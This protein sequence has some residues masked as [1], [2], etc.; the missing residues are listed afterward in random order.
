MSHRIVVKQDFAQPLEQ[1]FALFAKH[2]NYNQILSPLQ[3]VRSQDSQ[4]PE[5]PDG[6]GSVRQM[7]FGPIKPIREKIIAVEGNKK[8]TYQLIGNP[9]IRYHQGEI[10]F[11]ALDDQH[12]EVRYQIDLATKLPF[13]HRLILPVLK[14][15]ITQGLRKVAQQGI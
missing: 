9:L 3:V 11:K 8:I 10:S 4:D 2:E 15:A 13:A 14:Q 6:V 1:V 5:S 12:T 7:G